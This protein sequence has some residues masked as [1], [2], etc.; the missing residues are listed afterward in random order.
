[1]RNFSLLA[2]LALFSTPA[3]AQEGFDAHGLHRA[4]DDGDLQDLLFVWRPEAQTPKSF[5]AS[6]IFE[7]ADQ[8]LVLVTQN[9]DDTVT[10]ETLLDHVFGMHAGVSV[11]LH[12]RLALTAGAPIWLS[13]R[14]ADGVKSGVG[15]GDVRLS[16][17]IGIIVPDE[18]DG[19]FGLSI[20]PTISLPSGD[21]QRL[22]GYDGVSGGG[23]LSAG[24]NTDVWQVVANVGLDQTPYTGPANIIGGRI[25]RTR[26]AGSY[27]VR[28][29]LAL[30]GEL[31]Y[32]PYFLEG[33]YPL[34]PERQSTRPGEAVFSARGRYDK[35]INWTI[36]GASALTAG[37]TAAR[38]RFFAGIGWTMGKDGPADLD[39]DGL[40]D[41]LDAC[42]KEAETFNDYADDD[43][44]PDALADL[45]LQVFDPYGKPAADQAVF[46][47]GAEVGRTD[48]RGMLMLKD[49]VPGE[50]LSF[51][52]PGS[53]IGYADV[54]VGDWVLEEGVQQR[55]VDIEWLPGTISVYA[56]TYRGDPIA[57]EVQIQG[58]AEHSPLQLDDYGE[59][60][61]VLEAGDWTLF[62]SAPEF[63][64]DRKTTTVKAGENALVEMVFTLQPAVIHVTEE[65]VV[66]LDQIRFD[67]DKATIKA[68][69]A[70]VVE[71]VA[72]ALLSFPEIKTVEIQG[73]T[74]DKGSNRYNQEL[75]QRRVEA[76]TEALAAQG[77][78]ADR[79]Q[80]VGYGEACPL[81]SNRNEEGRAA[82]RR[83][84]F[85]IT[86][87]APAD[88]VPCHDGV[89]A[90]V[91]KEQ[92]VEIEFSNE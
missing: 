10:E 16:A 6:G 48:S 20:V 54:V 49:Q 24:Y 88:G 12:E 67:F 72:T 68:Q 13:S 83:V 60:M 29:D 33:A 5:S 25:L 51:K 71:Q 63:G 38:F 74:D 90:R 81:E 65:E 56:Q 17:P 77:V 44:C 69:S 27:L 2:A 84:Q 66:L 7:Y 75:S 11:G 89:K 53:A 79:M 82:N 70:D 41:S 92:V 46:M 47:D 36:G 32:D 35:G 64:T 18:A 3:L 52:I 45:S 78:S 50:T 42:P 9:A 91:S 61:M 21:Q 26:L 80:A 55:Q 43:G 39:L 76:V 31:R 14:G 37:A 73:H 30:R 57:A 4:P 40:V 87:P 19:G 59:G 62:A 86:D 15:I 8:P 34:S 23:A 28:E 1:M 85:I 58:P 22:L